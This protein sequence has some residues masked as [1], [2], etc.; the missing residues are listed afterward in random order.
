ME[1][2]K[3]YTK[4]KSYQLQKSSKCTFLDLKIEIQGLKSITKDYQCILYQ[5]IFIRTKKITT[6]KPTTVS[7]CRY[8]KY[9]LLSKKKNSK[10][11]IL[12]PSYKLNS[13]TC[14]LSIAC[15]HL[16]KG[17]HGQLDT[18]NLMHTTWIASQI[19]TSSWIKS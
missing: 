17:R 7:F 19:N 3:I 10:A 1:G 5:C 16:D 18:Y 4:N 12:F 13:W 6:I 14:L 8:F 2:K 15:V 9:K 11:S